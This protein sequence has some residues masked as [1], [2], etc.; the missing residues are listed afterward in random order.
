MSDSDNRDLRKRTFPESAEDS[1]R[2]ADPVECNETVQ[3]EKTVGLVSG[4]AMI[5]GTMIGELRLLLWTRQTQTVS[6]TDIW[7]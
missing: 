2:L 7:L 3:L 5:V 1:S 4:W 6:M